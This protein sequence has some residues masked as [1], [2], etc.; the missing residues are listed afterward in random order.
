M[1]GSEAGEGVSR[2]A[3]QEQGLSWQEYADRLSEYLARLDELVAAD[4]V[5]LGGGGSEDSEQFLPLL[6]TRARVVAAT[7]ENSAGMVGA[8]LAAASRATR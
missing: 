3:R 8:A 4:L 2:E 5:I 6:R 7:L 1:N